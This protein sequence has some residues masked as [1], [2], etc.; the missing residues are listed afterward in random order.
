M[1]LSG[2]QPLTKAMMDAAG[3][4]LHDKPSEGEIALFQAR[5][6]NFQLISVVLSCITAGSIDGVVQAK[7]FA[8]TFIPASK[9]DV[10]SRVKIDFVAQIDV[11]NWLATGPFY[12]G[13]DPFSGAWGLFG[14]LPGYFEGHRTGFFDEI[15]IVIDQ[16]FLAESIPE[17]DEIL[18]MDLKMP[19]VEMTRKYL[20]HRKKLFFA[21]FKKVEA[22]R[23]WGA[24]T[25]IE[26]FVM[27]GLAKEGLYPE[28]QMLI[29]NDGSA[30]PSLYNLWQD[31]EFRH[32]TGL[33]T[34]ADLF[35]PLQRVAVFCDG[36]HHSRPAQKAKD[37]AIDA[38]LA[39]LGITPV[40]LPSKEIKSD[41][42]KSIERV[43]EAVLAADGL[44]AE[45]T[46]LVQ[47]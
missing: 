33:I 8:V 38:K 40:R 22:R 26:L 42:A 43:K 23:I 19:S 11:S 15:G 2:V 28:S 7:P 25:P 20:K 39:A 34:E 13:Y 12:S 3:G 47:T 18:M 46:R 37:A 44:R 1:D 41:L 35:F 36:T 29:M 5:D 30:F 32:T 10:V 6:T 16:F 9:R 17:E 21:P 24:E 4:E 45:R 14:N 27:Q 31:L